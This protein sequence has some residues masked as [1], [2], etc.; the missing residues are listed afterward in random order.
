[1][2]HLGASPNT[3]TGKDHDAQKAPEDQDRKMETKAPVLGPALLHWG[4]WE[5]P[6]PHKTALDRLRLSISLGTNAADHDD[7][8]QK[9]FSAVAV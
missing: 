4:S 9:S 3:K 7:P 8:L 6:E 2:N 5:S 1:M